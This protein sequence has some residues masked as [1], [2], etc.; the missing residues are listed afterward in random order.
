MFKSLQNVGCKNIT[1]GLE[2]P[3]MFLI[4]DNG[5][6]VKCVFKRAVWSFCVPLLA[7]RVIPQTP[8]TRVRDV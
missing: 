2:S 3:L 5:F 6:W 8:S 1:D 4:D 7:V